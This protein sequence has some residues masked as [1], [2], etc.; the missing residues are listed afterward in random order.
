M[1]YKFSTA[2]RNAMGQQVVDA[3]DAGSGV[4]KFKF[5]T[6]SLGVW[7]ANRAYVVGDSVYA[8]GRNYDCTM[9]GTSGG[10]APTWPASG[11]V[12][13]GTVVWTEG[14]DAGADTL[15]GTLTCSDPAASVSGG[16]VTFGAIGEDA[17]ADANGRAR[18]VV[19]TDSADSVAAE[20]DVSGL[21]GNGVVKLNTVTIFAGGPIQMASQTITIG[22]A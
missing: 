1:I 22:G 17:M 10:S 2:L 4:G 20:F 13:D 16:V 21:A 19:L 18:K 15:L 11:T 14:D 12:N 3:M 6:R 8:G 9:A 5:Q 7:A